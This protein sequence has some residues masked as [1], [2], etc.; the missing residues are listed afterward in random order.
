MRNRLPLFLVKLFYYEYWPFWLFFLPLVPY[1]LFLAIKHRSLTFF[2]LAN[3]VIPHGGVFGESK[4]DILNKIDSEYLP[5]AIYCN[6]DV[7]FED[8]LVQLSAQKMEFPL[9]AKP[10]VGERGVQ[11]EKL[12]DLQALKEYIQNTEADF[13]IQEFI[14]YPIELGVLYFRTPLSEQSGITSIVQKEFLKVEGDGRSTVLELINKN[15]RA[16]LQLTL[17]REKWGLTLDRVLEPEE[18]LLL[19]PIGNHCLGTKFLSANELIDDGLVKIFD[20]IS[21]AIDGFHYGRFDLKVRSLD[22]LKKG[23]D[24]LIMELNGVTSEPGHIYDPKLNIFRAYRDTIYS[25]SKL[26]NVCKENK[27][28]GFKET[29]VKDFVQL[30]FDHFGERKVREVKRMTTS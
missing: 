23:K 28:L 12:V 27:S 24:I 29:S 16:K 18:V 22:S 14:D 11:V 20:K 21:E 15:E 2:T 4:S 10:D 17:L 8:V 9:V 13:I 5:G 30:I 3:P 7:G 1:W 25:V 19:Q 26:S 6:A